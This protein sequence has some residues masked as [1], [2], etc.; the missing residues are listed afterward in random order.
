[1]LERY[2]WDL[3]GREFTL[4]P[5]GGI[6]DWDGPLLRI[7]SLSWGGFVDYRDLGGLDGDDLDALI[8][9]Q[10]VYFRERGQAFEWKAFSHDEP[11][12]LADHLRAAGF[13]PEETETVVA[14]PLAAIA[15][16]VELPEGVTLREITARADLDRIAKH[17]ADVWQDGD[18]RAWLAN[19]LEA[20]HAADPSLMRFFVVE[21][22]GE[23]VCAAW[24]RLVRGT[25]WASLWGGATRADWRRRGVYRA[26]VRHRANV[27]LG[28]G[29]ELVQV[30]ASEDSR[31]IL[32][33]LGFTA[34]TV[35]TPWRWK[36]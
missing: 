30:D 29:Y 4:M 10:V 31:P 2:D 36:P 24:I 19:A 12:D 13:E 7:S 3:R 25:R 23:I 21:A 9:R 22:S 26:T 5:A 20:E 28:E 11:A 14:A 32:E 15:G 6:S 18:D 34:L 33:R 16:D 1:M 35:T 8:A 27:A 17:E